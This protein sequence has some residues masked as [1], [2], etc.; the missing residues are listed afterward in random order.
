[1]KVGVTA[2]TGMAAVNIR[3]I[4]LHSW[5]GIGLGNDEPEKYVEAIKHGIE[6]VRMRW[7]SVETLII[8]E[9]NVRRSDPRTVA[10]EMS[11]IHDR[12]R[13]VR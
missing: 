8:D 6:K 10:N 5:A 3:G 12:C 4:T 2:S 9:S 7:R 11:S 1:M 13:L